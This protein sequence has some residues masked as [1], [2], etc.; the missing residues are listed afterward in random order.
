LDQVVL[1]CLELEAPR[2]RHVG[3][4][5][6]AEIGQPGLRTDRGELGTANGD[7]VVALRA[8]I[9]K[10]FERRVGHRSKFYIGPPRR[11]RSGRRF[12]G[13]KWGFPGPPRLT[14]AR[15]AG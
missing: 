3:D 4:P 6:L 1:E 11:R 5:N 2:V 8:G 7:L 12:T 15:G 13:G 9:G 14:L 10:G